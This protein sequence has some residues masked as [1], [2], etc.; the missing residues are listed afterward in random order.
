MQ[1]GLAC[2]EK[3]LFRAAH[4]AQGAHGLAGPGL[5]AALDIARA[6]GHAR[7]GRLYAQA[8]HPV[9]D[10]AG[11]LVAALARQRPARRQERFHQRDARVIVGC[12]QHGV[13]QGQPV[14]VEQRSQRAH[15]VEQG[16]HVDAR[17]RMQGGRIQHHHERVH[18]AGVVADQRIAA[19]PAEQG[20][21]H[22][23]VQQVGAGCRSLDVARQRPQQAAHGRGGKT[24][25]A[26]RGRQRRAARGVAHE[27]GAHAGSERGARCDQAGQGRGGGRHGDDCTG[28]V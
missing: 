14:G 9:L 13:G 16:R 12:G 20:R 8:A 10:G 17:Q 19:R 27:E 6:T 5:D 1:H 21:R 26:L 18:G 24:V 25:Q 3:R 28:N 22:A 4:A 11:R 2:I 23:H 15:L 7:R